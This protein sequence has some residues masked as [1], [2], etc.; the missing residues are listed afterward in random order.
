MPKA[1]D[2]LLRGRGQI[3]Y[4]HNL[5][6]YLLYTIGVMGL[7]AYLAFFG[8]IVRRYWKN[9]SW[10]CGDDL[11]DGMT[12]LALLMV[13]IIAVDQLKIE[14]LRFG[15]V[16]Y[17]QFVFALLAIYLGIGDSKVPAERSTVQA[18]R[19]QSVPFQV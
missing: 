6:L 1:S 8:S 10:S 15:T 7:F 11:S 17:L 13:V 19:R 2:R 12:K 4:P 5:Y 16:D 18:L 9:A 3:T 14:F